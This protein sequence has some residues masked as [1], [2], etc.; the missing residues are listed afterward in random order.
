VTAASGAS[1]GVVYAWAGSSVGKCWRD[2]TQIASGGGTDSLSATF[3]RVQVGRS[4]TSIASNLNLALTWAVAEGAVDTAKHNSFYALL[5]AT[6]C[7]ALAALGLAAIYN[8][9]VYPH[10][11]GVEFALTKPLHTLSTKGFT[12][13]ADGVTI[14]IARVVP[15]G[16]AGGVYWELQFKDRW[17]TQGQEVVIEYSGDQ[18]AHTAGF[19]C[20]E[21]NQDSNTTTRALTDFADRTWMSNHFNTAT[22]TIAN[23]TSGQLAPGDSPLS[24]FNPTGL[25]SPVSL[26]NWVQVAQSIN[27][28]GLMLTTKHVDGYC[29]WD[30]TVSAARCITA[31]EPWWTNQGFDIVDAFCTRTRAAG[32]KVGFYFSILD[33]R[34]HLDHPEWDWNDYQTIPEANEAYTAYIHA[35]LTELLDGRYGAIDKILLD[36]WEIVGNFEYPSYITVNKASTL[37]LIRSLQPDIVILINDYKQSNADTEI[38]IYESGTAQ[39]IPRDVNRNAACYW[40]TPTEDNNG[41]FDDP[42]RRDNYATAASHAENVALTRARQGYLIWNIS[43]DTSGIYDAFQIAY[44]VE[45][46][47]AIGA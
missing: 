1:A 7:P 5:K 28:T 43:P 27:A 26:D 32:M 47:N 41:W 3:D 46:G 42:D 23:S 33:R 14:P 11:N 29:L 35:Q 31:S 30:S 45:V 15:S 13:K 20:S 25:T 37:A 12:I 2:T 8:A 36:A 39:P 6:I 16:G 34:F 18:F 17:I 40:S 4:A 9:Y 24:L 21:A 22:Y 44:C 38:A 10:G 19:T